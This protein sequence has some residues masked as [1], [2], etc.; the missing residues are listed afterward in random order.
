MN[1]I[2]IAYKL[3][4]G[5]R[6]HRRRFMIALL[7]YTPLQNDFGSFI[8]LPSPQRRYRLQTMVVYELFRSFIDL[9]TPPKDFGI[10]Y[11][12]VVIH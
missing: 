7:I 12:E 1:F 6:L 2:G 11:N 3:N 8:D 5:Y 4:D 9:P 10:A